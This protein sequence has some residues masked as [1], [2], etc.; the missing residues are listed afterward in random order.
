MIAG[1]ING[2]GRIG[3][4]SQAILERHPDTLEVAA[5]ND[6]FTPRPM[7]IC[8]KY[9][10]NYGRSERSSRGKQHRRKRQKD[11]ELRPADPAAIPW[12]T[13]R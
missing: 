3:R 5:V 13:R 10:T 11:K 12:M 6:L 9:D 2:F 7:P 1:S 4:R 8:F